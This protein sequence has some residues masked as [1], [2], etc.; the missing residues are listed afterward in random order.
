MERKAIEGFNNI[1]F[2]NKSANVYR[3]NKKMSPYNNGIGYWQI[4]LRK[5]GQRKSYY[6]HRLVWETFMGKIPD[7]FEINHIDHDKSHNDLDNLEL[8]THSENLHK[9]FLQHGYF[10][11]MN[12]PK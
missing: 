7:G 5:D 6:L 10:G 8:V 9:A 1:Y 12:R 4:K 3:Y 2:I 11:S